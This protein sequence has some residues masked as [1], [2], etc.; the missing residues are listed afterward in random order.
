[1]SRSLRGD[2]VFAGPCLHPCMKDQG[3]GPRARPDY[4]VMLVLPHASFT[5]QSRITSSPTSRRACVRRPQARTVLDASRPPARRLRAWPAAS[6]DRVCAAALPKGM[7]SGRRNDQ[8]SNKENS[9][10]PLLKE[11]LRMKLTLDKSQLPYKGD[12]ET[13]GVHGERAQPDR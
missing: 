5:G 11:P 10:T 7:R 2:P 12:G 4:K 8:Q 1:M 9:P 3:S 13:A 6:L